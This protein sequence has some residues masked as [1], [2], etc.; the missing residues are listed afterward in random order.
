MFSTRRSFLGPTKLSTVNCQ[1]CQQN[2]RLSYPMS[3]YMG[4][5]VS[6]GQPKGLSFGFRP[7]ILVSVCAETFWQ[8]FPYGQKSFYGINAQFQPKY[9]CSF[10]RK[11]PV[12]TFG[13][14][15]ALSAKPVLFWQFRLSTEIDDFGLP[16]FGFGRN[17]FG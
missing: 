16:S 11:K 5:L 3:Y 15:K 17:S 14:K 4:R 6:S 9:Y 1:N 2:C 13:R 10:G 7:K 8:N 12:S